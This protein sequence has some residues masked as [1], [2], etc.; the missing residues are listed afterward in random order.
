MQNENTYSLSFKGE[1]E[2][3]FDI[4]AVKEDIAKLFGVEVDEV[5][6]L[7]NGS[8][9]FQRTGLNKFTVNQ[10]SEKLTRIGAHCYID[11]NT[12]S[13][14]QDSLNIATASSPDIHTQAAIRQSVSELNLCPKCHS[15]NINSDQCLDCGV[16]FEKL[17]TFIPTEPTSQVQDAHNTAFDDED[18]DYLENMQKA[19]RV[20]KY[21]TIYLLAV[22]TVDNYFMANQQSLQYIVGPNTNIGV[23]PYLL[24][25]LGLVWGCYYLALAKRRSGLWG[26]MGLASLPGLSVLLLLPNRDGTHSNG[27]TQ[28]FSVAMILLSIYWISGFFINTSAQNHFYEESLLLREG[29]NEYPSVTFDED[30]NLFESE[31]EEL[32]AF[33]DRGFK[34]LNEHD[35]VSNPVSAIADTMFSE[36]MRLFIWADYQQYLQ[37][38]NGEQGADYL[39]RENIERAKIAIVKRIRKDVIDTNQFGVEQAYTQW[40]LIMNYTG[41]YLFLNELNRDLMKN[42]M[43]LFRLHTFTAKGED[44]KLIPPEFSFE[45]I[46]KSVFGHSSSKMKML[47][48]DDIMLFDFSLLGL[49]K[50]EKSLAI[51]SFYRVYKQYSISERKKVDRYFLVQVQ[52]SPDFPNKYLG[53]DFSA[54]KTNGDFNPLLN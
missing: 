42:R 28:L 30:A 12:T 35:Y 5:T 52:I 6:P 44:K 13:E 37:Y 20:I 34:L 45:H 7:F 23:L 24:G 53:G 9:L 27:K 10:Y 33:L 43:K 46:E 19:I 32:N 31:I 36:T 3:G 29:R 54:F 51:A 8:T 47:I 25:H 2:A 16:Y 38:R 17:K 21:V 50:H 22:F 26:G 39:D 41:K 1:V 11:E 40:F 15:E 18:S 4:Q 48:Q 49:E 14:I